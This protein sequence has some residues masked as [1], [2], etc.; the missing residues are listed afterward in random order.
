MSKP[1][2]RINDQLLQAMQAALRGRDAGASL[3]DLWPAW[4]AATG[5]ARNTLAILLHGSYNTRTAWVAYKTV[6]QEA[7]RQPPEPQTS[8]HLDATPRDTGTGRHAALNA[9]AMLQ[10]RA[11]ATLGTPPKELAR[12]FHTTPDIVKFILR[13]TYWTKAMREALAQEQ[14]DSPI[15]TPVNNV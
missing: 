5:L 3:Q 1:Q 15:Q 13:G 7:G 2:W 4:Q 12:R 14:A 11:A 6:A 8:R 9:A 10:M